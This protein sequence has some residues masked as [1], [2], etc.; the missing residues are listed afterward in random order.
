MRQELANQRRDASIARI[1]GRQHGVLSLTQLNDCG[2]DPSG[3]TRRVAAGR[4]HRIHRGV[5]A[6]GHAALSDEGRWMA[7]VLACGESA[8]LSHRSAARLW[9]ILAA[10]GRGWSGPARS[11][12]DVTVPGN[13]GR[14]RRRGI[15]GHRSITLSPAHCTIRTGIPV[16][17]PRRT[18]A[19]LRP[20]LSSAK[21][22]SAL[23]EAE[24]LKLPIGDWTDGDRAHRTR[25]SLP[26]PLPPP[27]PSSAGGER[28]YRSIRGRFSLGRSVPRGGGRRLGIAPDAIRIREGPGAGRSPEGARIRGGAV[29]LATD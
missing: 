2:V 23:R 17:T 12:V 9:G 1:A 4:L 29:H 20:V 28:T 14:A 15:R 21:F 22:A 18:L 8:V 26:Q 5:Y 10:S 3:V 27:S 25:G 11:C 19:D 6:V 16:T 13:G 7:A 24:F